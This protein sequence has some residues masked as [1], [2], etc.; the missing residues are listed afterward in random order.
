MCVCLCYHFAE[1]NID[2]IKLLLESERSSRHVKLHL[3]LRDVF[4]LWPCMHT[5]AT[6]T[7]AHR[8]LQA[9]HCSWAVHGTAHGPAHAGVHQYYCTAGRLACCKRGLSSAH[10]HVGD[11]RRH[12]SPAPMLLARPPPCMCHTLRL[13]QRARAAQRAAE[14]GPHHHHHHK[15]T[16]AVAGRLAVHTCTHPGPASAA[17][18]ARLNPSS[19][20]QPSPY[21]APK[22]CSKCPPPWHSI[23]ARGGSAAPAHHYYY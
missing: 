6:D 14:Q 7:R 15:H 20:K 4:L 8:H 22:P 23:Q 11:K 5:A 17:R 9:H 3:A 19:N 2:V 18:V 12:L 13:T 16:H 21:S 10:A 1:A